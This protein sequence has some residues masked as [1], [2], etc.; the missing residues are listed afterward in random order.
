M[1]LYEKIK[2]LA[3][4]KNVSIRQIEGHLGYGNGTIRRWGKQTPGVDKVQ[5]VAKYFNV[6]VD[7]LLG[8]K[9]KPFPSDADLADLIDHS[10]HFDG[11]EYPDDV[12]QG[13]KEVLRAYLMGRLDEKE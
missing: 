9:E 1:D 3:A 5:E 4:Q 10:S 12:K 6:S 13:M 8:H 2:Q 7:Y 11:K